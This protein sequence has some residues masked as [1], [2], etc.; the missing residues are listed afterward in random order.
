MDLPFL[1]EAPILVRV[2]FLPLET[3]AVISNVG[4]FHEDR[5]TLPTF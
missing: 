2:V 5:L 4:V 3:M 1:P